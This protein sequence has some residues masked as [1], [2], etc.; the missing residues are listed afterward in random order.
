MRYQLGAPRRYQAAVIYHTPKRIGV[1][2]AIGY[3]WSKSLVVVRGADVGIK[4]GGGAQRNPRLY[5]VARSAGFDFELRS[6]QKTLQT[7]QSRLQRP[8]N[9]ERLEILDNSAYQMSDSYTNLLYH[10]VFSTKERRPL[11]TPEYEP[12]AL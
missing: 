6:I 8:D 2:L 4:P 12:R 7:P 1:S 10:I 5:A 3:S 11:I 9:A